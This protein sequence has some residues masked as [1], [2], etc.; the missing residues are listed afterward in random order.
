MSREHQ[1]KYAVRLTAEE[2]VQL[3]HSARLRNAP[4]AQVV[5]AKILL[6]AYEQ[7]HWSNALIARRLGGAVPTVRK[8]RA[9]SQQGPHL[10]ES[11]RSGAPRFFRF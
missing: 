9:A 10:Q 3:E 4:Y 8:W 6:A 1:P 2:H 11:P 5:R 7:P